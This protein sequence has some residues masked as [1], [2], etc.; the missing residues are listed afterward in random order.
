MRAEKTSS[1]GLLSTAGLQGLRGLR[2]VG[3]SLEEVEASPLRGPVPSFPSGAQ[4][5]KR[6]QLNG[7]PML[8]DSDVTVTTKGNPCGGGH[9]QSPQSPAVGGQSHHFCVHVPGPS[10]RERWSMSLC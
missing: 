2:N 1:P 3:T 4:E 6:G 10:A 5:G 7:G 8:G 9:L